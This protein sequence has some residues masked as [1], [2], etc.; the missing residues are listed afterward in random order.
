MANDC[1]YTIKAVAKEKSALER[2]VSIMEYKDPEYFIYRCFE[3]YS[4]IFKDGDYYVA[5]ISGSVAWSCSNWFGHEEKPEELIV[6]KYDEN[7][8]KTYGTSHY[9]TLDLLCKKLGVGI[10]LYS[11]ESGCCFQEHYLVDVNG[12][13]I[14]DES[15]EWTQDWW[16]EEN[17]C[18]RDEPITTGGFDDYCC[19]SYA[20]E[21]YGEL[22]MA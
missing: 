13:I 21:I 5:D 20:N 3:A 7:M 22:E 10:E 1:L 11:E 15:C 18:E 9:I 17:D 12:N 2:L 19:F 6:L 14:I 8:N 4:N 16:D